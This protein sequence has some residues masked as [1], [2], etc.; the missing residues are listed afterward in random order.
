MKAFI[1][2]GTNSGCGKTT[3]TMGIMALL[4]KQGYA[5]APFK[6]G[7][8]F[9]DPMFHEMVTGEPSYNLDSF[10]LK[11]DTLKQLFAKHTQNKT[12]AI[13]EGVMG[14]YDGLG[15]DGLGSTAQLA[16][17]LQLPVVLVVNCKAL[18]QSAAAIVKGFATFSPNVKV[19]GAILNHVQ[20]EEQYAFLKSYIETQ[21]GVPCFGYLPTNK[22]I[23]LESRHLGLLQAE[24]VDNLQL[25]ID[26]LIEVFEK[27]LDVEALLNCCEW[28]AD[29][30]VQ[31][32]K[33]KMVDLTGIHLAVAYDRAF[34]FYYRDNLELL[35]ECGASLHFFSPLN[36]EALPQEAN[37]VYIGG[38]YPEV[39]ANQLTGNAK[40]RL[41]IRRKAEKGMPVY[42]ECGG[43]MYLTESIT[44]N[45]GEFAMVGIFSCR[46]RMTERLQRFG[47]AEV[48]YN[49][50]VTRCHEFH[51]S[52]LEKGDAGNFDY[53]FQ[54]SKPLKEKS[55][56]CGLSRLN[57]LAGYAHLHFYSDIDFF[58]QI[59]S[60][61]K[62]ATM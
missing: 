30:T 52:M 15:N 58:K 62:R 19:V 45:E 14:M 55:W 60:L 10:L 17:M 35:E 16:E 2:A 24:E 47:Y 51:R 8:D 39:F 34:R 50:V 53:H 46:S 22:E 4:S 12:V 21:T 31:Q 20:S 1:L 44:S 57:V 29:F 28:N 36:D 59:A 38:G 23:V 32:E 25:K 41:D 5:V 48:K 3:V 49:G 11:E 26:L 54:L 61:W 40:M 9:I 27:T 7:P 42:A 13:V 37:A 43:L 33:E 6:T 18:Y 56:E